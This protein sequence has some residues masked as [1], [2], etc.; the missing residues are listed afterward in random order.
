MPSFTIQKMTALREP[1][2]QKDQFIIAHMAVDYGSVRL[3]TVNLVLTFKR[4]FRVMIPSY[5][6]NRVVLTDKEERQQ[7]LQSALSAYSAL[8][9]CNF[10]EMPVAKAPHVDDT[11]ESSRDAGAPRGDCR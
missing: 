5:G 2:A 9:G 3:S 10:A 7:L 1:I 8:T 11:N 6:R 4:E